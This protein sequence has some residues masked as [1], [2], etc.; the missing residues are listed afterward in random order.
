VNTFLT[1]KI[2]TIFILQIQS[3]KQLFFSSD[4]SDTKNMSQGYPAGDYYNRGQGTQHQNFNVYPQQQQQVVIVDGTPI[5]VTEEQPQQQEFRGNHGERIIV[6]REAPQDR[7]YYTKDSDAE[8]AGLCA[9]LAAL[10]CC[11]CC[12]PGPADF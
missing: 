10:L 5:Y 7:R 9:C 8:D 2:R 11:C 1:Q 12:L 4:F 3:F 6:I